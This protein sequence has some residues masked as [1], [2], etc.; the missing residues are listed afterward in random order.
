[1][2]K[3]IWTDNYDYEHHAYGKNNAAYVN[4]GSL[5]Q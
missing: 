1:M 3:I 4:L 2:D 5:P